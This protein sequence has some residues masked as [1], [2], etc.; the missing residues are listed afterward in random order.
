MYKNKKILAIIPAR[1]GSKRIKNKNLKKIN[2]KPLIYY[3]LKY[4]LDNKKY[5]D[6]FFLSTD[7]KKISKYGNKVYSNI[8]P[9]LRP[10]NISKD[11]SGDI[12]FIKHALNYLKKKK[13]IIFDLVVIFRPTTPIRKKNLFLSC[14]KTLEKNN[15]SSVRS[16][17]CVKHLH[18]YW[19][20]KIKNNKLTE[21]IRNKNFFK[22]YQSQKLPNFFMHDGHCDIF[23]TKNLSNKKNIRNMEKIYGKKMTYFINKQEISINI[24]EP[25]EFFIAKTYLEKLIKRNKRIS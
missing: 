22:Y 20:Y 10:K 3:S 19:M 8:S 12:G 18:P 5:I 6:E 17:K 4:A 13:N 16:A 21:V 9:I 15:A 14:L 2:S 24:D 23:L 7:S 11:K 25:F 1:S